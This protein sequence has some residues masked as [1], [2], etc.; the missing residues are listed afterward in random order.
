MCLLEGGG[1]PDPSYKPPPRPSQALSVAQMP[2]RTGVTGGLRH[3]VPNDVHSIHYFI[4]NC[5]AISEAAV[6]SPV[7]QTRKEVPSRLRP[8]ALKL[9]PKAL[10]QFSV[11]H[12]KW[13]QGESRQNLG[14]VLTY[15]AP[16]FN[17]SVH[18]QP[19][20]SQPPPMH[21]VPKGLEKR[22][23]TA[24]I[25]SLDLTRA[26]R[27]CLSLHLRA[28][29]AGGGGLRAYLCAQQHPQEAAS[30]RILRGQPTVM[31]RS[32]PESRPLAGTLRGQTRVQVVPLFPNGS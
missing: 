11:S 3:Q 24:T 6:I 25:P 26:P 1:P 8:Q 7:L 29:R 28:T 5:P 30:T 32:G 23:G 12:R 10:L 15:P 2:A 4:K 21:L 27:F 9:K 17:N 19:C 22:K 31:G 13:K 16:P 14:C 18:S 20:V